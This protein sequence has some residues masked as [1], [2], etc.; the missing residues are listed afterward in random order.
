MGRSELM[1]PM[2]A[3]FRG[4][5][6]REMT[7]EEC[8]QHLAWLLDSRW[9]SPGSV[10]KHDPPEGFEDHVTVDVLGIELAWMNE[11]FPKEKYTWYLWF[12]SVFVV[13]KDSEMVT[14]LLLKWPQSDDKMIYIDSMGGGY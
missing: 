10:G 14:A 13:P 3:N 8:D 12:E 11:T 2:P 1:P 4:L 6:G 5:P 9:G 7:Q